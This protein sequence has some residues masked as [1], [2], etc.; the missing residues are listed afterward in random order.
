MQRKTL[1]SVED[2]AEA[3]QQTASA[4]PPGMSA[5]DY[6]KWLLA[7]GARMGGPL[8]GGAA[9]LLTSPLTGPVGPIAG[10]VVGGAAGNPLQSGSPVKT[11][12]LVRLV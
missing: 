12:T 8:V 2:P 3:A 1:K 4:P 9:G 10:G 6:M 5:G 7:T 11:K